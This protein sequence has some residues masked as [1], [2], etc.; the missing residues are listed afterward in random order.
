MD[1]ALLLLDLIGQAGGEASLS[2]LAERSGLNISTCHHLLATLCGRRYVAKLA[3]KRTY[4]L[5][6]QVL[7]LSQVCMKH[8]DLPQRAQ[9]HLERISAATGETVHVAVLHGDDL[10]TIAQRQ[11]RHAVR[12]DTGGVGKAGAAHATATGKSILAWL[13]D[14]Q[15]RRILAAKHMAAFTGNTITDPDLLIE[16]L[17]HVRR[18]GFAMDREEF[19]PGVICVG[20]PIR[21]HTGAVIGSISASAPTMR[22]TTDHLERMR[23]EVVAATRALSAELGDPQHQRPAARVA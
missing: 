13:P 5:G 10:I 11:A 2:A 17:R 22:A 3:G 12:V 15:I 20:A 19:Q 1:R 21:D 6:S 4:G 9:I 8:V 18:N 16:E 23:A 14:D 7:H